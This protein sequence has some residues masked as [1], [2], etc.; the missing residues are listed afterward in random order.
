VKRRNLDEPCNKGP[1]EPAAVLLASSS[2]F[3]LCLCSHKS[4]F[5]AV[6]LVLAGVEVGLVRLDT[7][8]LHDELVAEDAD[9]VDGNTLKVM[10]AY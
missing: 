7:L 6:D 10:L 9:K 4:L 3:L 2:E 5:L 8:R 1:V